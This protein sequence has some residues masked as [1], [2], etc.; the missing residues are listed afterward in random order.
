M[1]KQ[2]DSQAEG[3]ALKNVSFSYPDGNKVLDGISLQILHGSFYGITGTNGS[4][5]TTLSLL[6]NGLIPHEIQGRMT[7]SVLV[8]GDDTKK[9]PV[10]FFARKVGMVFQNPDHM[11]FN[12]SVREELE[13]GLRNIGVKD[14][15]IRIHEALVQVGLDGFEDRDPH[16][17]SFGQKQKLCLACVLSMNPG[18]IVLDEATSMLDYKSTLQMYAILDRLHRKGNTIVIIEHD[19][20]FLKQYASEVAVIHQGRIVLQGSAHDVFSQTTQ[21]HDIGIKIP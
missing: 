14:F 17:L 16:S 7:G 6:L 9:K 4:G 15:D 2:S 19:T 10:S 12:L 11:I 1:Q 8:E 21:L 18:Y 20:S 13:F 5:K 3:I